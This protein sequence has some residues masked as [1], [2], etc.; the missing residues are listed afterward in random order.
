VCY[1]LGKEILSFS[2]TP[3]AVANDSTFL[4]KPWEEVK[5]IIKDKKLIVEK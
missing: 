2:L 1:I 3:S 4:F 5:I